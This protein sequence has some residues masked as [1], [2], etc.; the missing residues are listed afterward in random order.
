VRATGMGW[1]IGIGRSGAILAP[2]VSGL[3]LDR[4][5]TPAQLYV[6]Y[7]VQAAIAAFAI[8]PSSN[9]VH[10]AMSRRVIAI[11][12]TTI[13]SALPMRAA[14]SCVFSTAL[15]VALVVVLH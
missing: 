12:N 6:L 13:S 1:A 10:I 8:T 5:W 15:D 11:P 3:L 4:G 2:L 9:A 14:S 7:S